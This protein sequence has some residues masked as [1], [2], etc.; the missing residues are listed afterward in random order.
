MELFSDLKLNPKI[1][2]AV[3]DAGYDKPTPIQEKAIPAA[4]D[5]KDVLGIAPVS[6]AHL[7]L[8]TTV[9]V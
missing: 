8:P 2:K 3:K 9:I 1:L 6:Y 5:G 7:T 4:L